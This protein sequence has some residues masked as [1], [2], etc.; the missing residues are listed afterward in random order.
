MANPYTHKTLNSLPKKAKPA[1]ITLLNARL[2][3]G[4]DLALAIKQAHWNVKGPTFI[5]LHLLLDTFRT[6]IDEHVDT[7]AERAVQL[8]GTALRTVE[9]VESTSSL[10]AYP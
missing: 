1:V 6:D 4:I 10:S 5:G 3:D 8:G 2:A 7:I 9:A